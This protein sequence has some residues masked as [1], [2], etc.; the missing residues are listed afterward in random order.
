ML[1][2]MTPALT[3]NCAQAEKPSHSLTF[4]QEG[5]QLFSLCPHHL[6]ILSAAW[7][8]AVVR[9]KQGSGSVRN[10]LESL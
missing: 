9:R 8:P 3:A 1:V 4:S 10:T 2:I 7:K 6:R 5:E